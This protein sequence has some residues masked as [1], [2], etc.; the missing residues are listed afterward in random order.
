[1]LTWFV[2][3]RAGVHAISARVSPPTR[4]LDVATDFDD[5]VRT[6]L[7][8]QSRAVVFQFEAHRVRWL[9]FARNSYIQLHER[10]PQNVLALGAF[11]ES[12]HAL[13]LPRCVTNSFPEHGTPMAPDVHGMWS[14]R[15][16]LFHK[17]LE[18]GLD[19]LML[20][21][22]Y[23]V[24]GDVFELL[25]S[26]CL[27]KAS[28]AFLAEGGG[29]NG[30]FVFARGTRPHVVANW[31]VGTVGRLYPTFWEYYK[32]T[33]HAPCS[34]MDQDIIKDSMLI[35]VTP[36]SSQWDLRRCWKDGDQNHVFW[37]GKP[38][39]STEL[40]TARVL[41]CNETTELLELFLPVDAEGTQT[42]KEYAVYVPP[43]VVRFGGAGPLA[44]PYE[45]KLVHQLGA[46][47]VWMP[48]AE[49][50]WHTGAHVSR[51]AWIQIDGGWSAD[52]YRDRA[53]RARLLFI[54]D[55]LVARVQHDLVVLR[56]TIA[57]ALTEAANAGRVLVLPQ[58]NCSVEWIVDKDPRLIWRARDGACFVGT[59]AGETCWPWEHVAYVFDEHVLARR[60][61]LREGDVVVNR[62][63]NT[64][65]NVDV[66]ETCATFFN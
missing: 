50:A 56:R 39:V 44:Y 19:V 38:K 9:D 40:P 28:I 53:E 34:T 43:S 5:V 16:D 52:V 33:G 24:L 4:V 22:D 51:Q 66:M 31:I 13:G 54:D 14:S 58:L 62:F 26:E 37:N 35:A 8:G 63:T 1:V 64:T 17:L 48:T 23:L 3:C 57:D 60:K 42:E 36:N 27:A 49:Q 45:T 46:R 47:G 21:T 15:Y 59:N 11:P 61:T 2:L 65:Q 12:C 55:A 10:Y 32:A 30:G 29:P 41:K 25:E 20:D 6:F 7:K 18:R